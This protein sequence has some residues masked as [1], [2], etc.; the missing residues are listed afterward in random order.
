MASNTFLGASTEVANPVTHSA[1]DFFERP[2]VLINYEGS[3]DQEVFPHVGCRGPQL[4][5]FVSADNKNCIDLNRICL[6]LEISLYNPDGK[7]AATPDNILFANN[8]LHSLFSHVELFLNGKLISSSN[9][10]YHHAAFVETELTTDPM[11][12]ETWARCQGYKYRPNKKKN[13]EIKDGMMRNFSDLGKCTLHLYGA[14]RVDFLDCERLLLPGVTLHLRFYRSPN[15]CAL[16]TLTDLDA[17][18][19]K[20]LDQNT[21]VVVIERASLFV[22]KIVLSET[23][24][25]SIE[26]ALTKSCAVY[27]YIESTTKSFIIQSGQNCFVKENIFGTEPIRRITLCMVR[28]RF[29]RGATTASTPFRYEKFDLQRVELL[30]GN[31]LPIAGTP[32]DTASNT[33]LYYNT[34]SALGFERS[35]NGITL[36]DY[37]ENHFFLVFDLTS[38]REAS[39]SLTLFPELTGAGLTLKLT[40][41]KALPEAVELFLIGERFSQVFIDSSRNISKNS[42]MMT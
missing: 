35:G 27:P 10:N 9:N 24:K 2:S 1:L 21:P 22:N 12:K 15:Q 25:L 32:L 33:R 37:E 19:A 11:S 17:G 28:N 5:F 4:D 14:P 34:I 30:R 42:P 18:A 26:R 41:C 38:T 20:T 39:K 7:D 31:G 16:E 3:F 8:T 40:F 13:V 29:F 23:V 36:D 6:D